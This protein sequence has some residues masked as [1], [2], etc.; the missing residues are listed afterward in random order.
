MSSATKRVAAVVLAV[1]AL[2]ATVAAA[3]DLEEAQYNVVVTLYNAGQWEAALKKIQEREAR[4]LSDPMRIK[5]M[6]ARG[7]A[8]EKGGKSGE[9]AR[10]YTALI[11]KYPDAAES[12]VNAMKIQALHMVAIPLVSGRA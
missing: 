5:Y 4:D 2:F 11:D 10:A 7:L 6:Y 3:A 12:T 9:A 1:A 8:L